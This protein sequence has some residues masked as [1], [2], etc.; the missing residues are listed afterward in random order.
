MKIKRNHLK[1]I[2]KMIKINKDKLWTVQFDPTKLKPKP[3]RHK[4]SDKIVNDLRKYII[5]EYVSL[6]LFVLTSLLSI[7]GND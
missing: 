6:L 1:L 3:L 4:I 2:S 5:S 7:A